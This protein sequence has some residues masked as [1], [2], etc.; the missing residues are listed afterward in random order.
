MRNGQNKQ[1]MRNRNNNNNNNNRRSQNPMTRVYESNGPD[2]K[3]RG[4]ASH[5]AEKYLQ[6]ARDARSSGDPVAAENYY[7][8]AEHYFRLIAAAQEQFRQNQQPRG[9]EPISSNSDDG[10]DDGEN[11]S[12]FGQEPGFVPQPQQQQPFARDR[13]GQRDHHQRDHQQREN[14]PYQRDQQQ[15]REHRERDHRPQPQYQ[16]Q[17]Q[18]Q[19]QPQ[20]VVTD[21]GSVDRLPSFITGAQPQVNGGANGGEGG[22]G[23]GER[24]PRRRRR[25][26]GP[27]P[28]REAAPAASGDDLAPSE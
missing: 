10:D 23:G 2:I 17:P 12:N 19:N 11:F 28:E 16:P 9:D 25:P 6:L 1:R 13:D 21:T 14:Q 8:H 26:H 5:I 18:P 24:F 22:A 4:T 20:P 3:I 7:Q 15:P 27:R